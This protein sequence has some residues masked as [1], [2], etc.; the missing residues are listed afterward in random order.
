MKYAKNSLT[1]KA[2]LLKHLTGI[3]ALISSKQ[4]Y[5]N[6]LKTMENQFNQLD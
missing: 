2:G 4:Q 6:L 1:G 5:K 3:N